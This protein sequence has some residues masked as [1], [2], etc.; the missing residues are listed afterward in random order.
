MK[1]NVLKSVVIVFAMMIA[2]SANAQT[3]TKWSEVIVQTDGHGQHCK[4]RIE[5]SI[6]YEKGVKNVEYELST[7]KVKIT[8]DSTKTTPDALRTALRKMG[9]TVDGISASDAKTNS[10]STDNQKQDPKDHQH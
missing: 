1:M 4:D 5:G 9:Y 2:I 8:Y 6:S 10:K 7:A 3:A